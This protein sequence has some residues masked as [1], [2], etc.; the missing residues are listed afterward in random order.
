MAVALET[1]R[2]LN[3]A[4]FKLSGPL[5]AQ[6][7]C[8]ALDELV[9]D[10]GFTPGMNVLAVFGSGT[11][12]CGSGQLCGGESYP[13]RTMWMVRFNGAGTVEWENQVT[14]LSDSMAG[15]QAD[16]R[17]V[18]WYQHHGRLAFDGSS[19]YAADLASL[20]RL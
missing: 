5:S 13:C 11:D 16:A 15:C 2:G 6:A 19:N 8:S 17:F 1:D 10:P 20:W 7:I 12:N 4:V 3:I 14:N 9:T 18:W